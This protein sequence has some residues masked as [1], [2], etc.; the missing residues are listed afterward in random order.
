MTSWLTRIVRLWVGTDSRGLAAL[1]AALG[2]IFTLAG[3]NGFFVYAGLKPFLPESPA[4]LDLLGT[5]YLLVLEKSVELAGGLLL[6]SG[7]FTSLALLA[8]LPLT[9]NIA[10]FHLFIDHN[11]L[12]P[13]LLMLLAHLYLLWT[14]RA[15]YAPILRP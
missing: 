11:L 14:R 6:L 4:A 7:R 10:A 1:R 12:L 3:I 15:S 13:V 5:G 8:L 9:V 2:L